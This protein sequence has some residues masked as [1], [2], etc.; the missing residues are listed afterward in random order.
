[1]KK[2][3]ISSLVVFALLVLSSVS[4]TGN[5]A[6]VGY[7]VSLGNSTCIGMECNTAILKFYMPQGIQLPQTFKLV[8]YPECFLNPPT[9]AENYNITVACYYDFNVTK[10][11]IDLHQ[12]YSPSCG[13]DNPIIIWQNISNRAGTWQQG[14]QFF[15]AFFCSFTRNETNT[16][17]IPTEFTVYV[18][19]LGF[20]NELQ[21][22]VLDRQRE[23][24]ADILTAIGEIFTINLEIW[25]MIFI[26]VE[27]LSVIFGV[28][29][30]IGFIPILLKL[31]AKKITGGGR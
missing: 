22:V 26:G 3:L 10:Q 28:I 29:F 19:T 5:L 1:M 6:V 16:E 31:I 25:R 13:S 27:I 23:V 7:T 12:A 17:R 8:I 30:L 2:S 9:V 20:T 4:A 24:G 18:D 21:E 14:S 11:V 15:D